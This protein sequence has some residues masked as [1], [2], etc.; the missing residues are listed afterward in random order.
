VITHA[1]LRGVGEALRLIDA[2]PVASLA[3]AL[4]GVAL[5]LGLVAAALVAVGAAAAFLGKAALEA[6]ELGPSL[7]QL[8]KISGVAAE[9]LSALQVAFAKG[10]VSRQQFAKEF[11]D[12]FRQIQ[13]QAPAI[14]VAVEQS[15]IKVEQSQQRTAQATLNLEKVMEEAAI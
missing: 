15:S 14:A 12:L 11:G 8:S 7:S 1:E 2:G 4:G 10:G 5:R 6:A 13:Q 3:T 9:D